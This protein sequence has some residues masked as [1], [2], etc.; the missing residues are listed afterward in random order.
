MPNRLAVRCTWWTPNR[1]SPTTGRPDGGGSPAARVPSGEVRR[2]HASTVGAGGAG[3]VTSLGV[4]CGLQ[5]P[6]RQPDLER[7]PARPA[8]DVHGSAMRLDHGRDDGEAE[9]GAAGAPDPRGLPAG[10]PVEDVG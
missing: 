8:L 4:R 6:R 2:A 10:E 5:D 1:G 7:R 9:P 3:C